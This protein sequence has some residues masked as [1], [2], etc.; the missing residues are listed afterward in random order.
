MSTILL[1]S[2]MV[3]TGSF[4]QSVQT[5]FAQSDTQKE[6]AKHLDTFDVSEYL[7]IEEGQSYLETTTGEG[8]DEKVNLQSG[9]IYFAI[10]FI[11]LLTK[12]IGSFALLFLI[13]GGL[14]LMASHGNSQL[15]TKGKQMILY[16]LL[17]VIVAF[18]S[19]IIVTFVQS[20]F[21]TT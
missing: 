20:L 14:I 17:G 6:E 15:Q 8:K 7:K 3:T 4:I 11:E 13:T 10:A 9:V 12:I 18:G 5:T 19:L 2:I 21:F 16:S 1:V